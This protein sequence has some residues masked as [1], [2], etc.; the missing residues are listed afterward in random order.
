MAGKNKGLIV[1]LDLHKSL[2]HPGSQN[3][4]E[5]HFLGMI[6]PTALFPTSSYKSVRIIPGHLNTITVTA[7]VLDADP[8][9]AAIDPEAR[10]CYFPTETQYLHL[11]QVSISPT[12]YSSFLI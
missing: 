2:Y 6:S 3:T 7:S 9:I 4:D 1:L 12:F 11:H 8:A 10:N 5:K